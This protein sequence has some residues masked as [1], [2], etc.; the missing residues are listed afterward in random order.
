LSVQEWILPNKIAKSNASN[1][2][3]RHAYWDVWVPEKNDKKGVWQL[4][5]DASGNEVIVRTDEIQ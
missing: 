3:L 1:F 5:K 2:G 4:Q